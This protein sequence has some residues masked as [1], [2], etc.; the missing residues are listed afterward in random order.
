MSGI[1][2]ND[3]IDDLDEV[4][5]L[6]DFESFSPGTHEAIISAAEVARNKKDTMN[7]LVVTYR[8]PTEEHITAREWLPIPEGKPSEWD[9]TVESRISQAGKK[10]D[11]SEYDRNM[12]SLRRLK[13]RFVEYGFPP[14]RV[15]SVQPED[16]ID[17]PVVIRIKATPSDKYPDS[18]SVA[19][20]K[21]RGSQE[22]SPSLP[23]AGKK[24]D[25]PFK[26]K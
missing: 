19:S 23:Q 15:G 3:L 4:E 21:G 13:T 5:L 14:E 25:N 10:Y 16:L 2:D 6:K 18:V 17:I 12:N 8:H 26:K 9:A 24:K 11:T 7:M 20:V 22:A 1:F